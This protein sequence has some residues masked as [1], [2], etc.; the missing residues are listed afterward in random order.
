MSCSW[1]NN[2]GGALCSNDDVTKTMMSLLLNCSAKN[3]ADAKA[4]QPPMPATSQQSAISISISIVPN[5]ICLDLNFQYPF[6]YIRLIFST[7]FGN[8]L[9]SEIPKIWVSAKKSWVLL[10]IRVFGKKKSDFWH[11][12]I[13]E[14]SSFKENGWV[15]AKF[16]LSFGKFWVLIS[17]SFATNVEKISLA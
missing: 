14:I 8:Y 10:N 5:W 17:L 15:M 1:W 3:V 16:C 12:D 4:I 2:I 7:F 6:N 13:L 11:S 9:F